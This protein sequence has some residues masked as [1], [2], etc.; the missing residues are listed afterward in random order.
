MFVRRLEP[1]ERRTI[2]VALGVLALALVASGW[3]APAI[4]RWNEREA[5]IAVTRDRVARLRELVRRQPELVAE[6][7]RREQRSPGTVRLLRG[8]TVALASSELQQ[9]LHAYA[10]ESRVSVNR[11]AVAD[12]DSSRSGATGIAATVSAVTDVYGLADL[13]GR[14]QGG[15]VLLSVDELSI[16]PNPVLRGNLLQVA[17]TVRAPFVLEP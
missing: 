13:L 9:L 4:R 8:R 11:L 1:R 15:A 6:A 16:A 12:P 5:A 7:D 3:V 10:R 2:A 17:V 14:L